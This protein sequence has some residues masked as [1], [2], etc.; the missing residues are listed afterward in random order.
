VEVRVRGPVAELER[1][2]CIIPGHDRAGIE[3]RA[4][5]LRVDEAPL[6]FEFHGMCGYESTFDYSSGDA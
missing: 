1:V 5:L 6:A 4:D 2:T 3:V